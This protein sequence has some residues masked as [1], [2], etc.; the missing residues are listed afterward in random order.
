MSRMPRTKLIPTSRA[1][2]AQSQLIIVVYVTVA[3]DRYRIKTT[4][5]VAELLSPTPRFLRARPVR[6]HR[7]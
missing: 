7:I 3:R 2:L 5:L 1:Q 6:V 4:S